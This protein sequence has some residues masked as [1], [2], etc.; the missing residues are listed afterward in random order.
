MAP[1]LSK[2]PEKAKD[3][4]SHQ[5]VT[6]VIPADSLGLEELGQGIIPQD[7]RPGQADIGDPGEEDEKEE[8]PAVFLEGGEKSHD[9]AGAEYSVAPRSIVLRL[10]AAGDPFG[11]SE[12]QAG[13]EESHQTGDQAG[14]Q[15]G[16]EAFVGVRQ[17]GDVV[18]QTQADDHRPCDDQAGEGGR[19]N[20]ADH[21]GWAKRT[22]PL[23]LV[24]RAGGGR[25]IHHAG[26]GRGRCDGRGGRT[27]RCDRCADGD[28]RDRRISRCGGRGGGIVQCGRHGE[29]T[30]AVRIYT[31]AFTF[32]RQR[33]S[34]GKSVPRP[35]RR[36]Y[37]SR[38]TSGPGLSIS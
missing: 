3:E 12:D 4:G 6:G 32:H 38:H 11:P 22:V 28:S 5:G 35:G 17:A 21:A 18:V 7:A 25:R 26:G 14:P 15:K 1:G 24:G 27:G 8:N 36:P 19:K 33:G 31:V 30:L 37:R 16:V 20:Q 23:Q 10:A 29:S 34:L 9:R 2:P 13:Q